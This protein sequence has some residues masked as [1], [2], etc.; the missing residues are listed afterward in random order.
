MRN[1]FALLSE[2]YAYATFEDRILA[3]NRFMDAALTFAHRNAARIKQACAAADAESLVAKRGATRSQMARGGVI[4]ILMGE[5]DPD[6]NPN[7]GANMNRR[8]PVIHPEQMIDML[9]FEGSAFEDIAREYYVPA[10]ATKAIELLQRH[11]VRMRQLTQP[12]TVV[13]QFTITSN[14]QRQAGGGIDFGTHGLRTL[15][16]AWAAAPGVTVPA[17]AWAV[18]TNQ[19]LGRLAFY[20]LAPTSD[21]GLTTWNYLDDL[22]G[23][24]VKIY[25]VLRKK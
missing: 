3:T 7:T 2:A 10:S 16:G 6:T 5:V 25:P 21:D 4:E 8:K 19:P 13:E 14:T 15:D 22:L 11:G 12:V 23:A 1:R 18:A 9:W 17:G 20:L 24:E